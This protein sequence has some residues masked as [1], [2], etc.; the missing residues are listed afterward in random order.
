[1]VAILKNV[2][3]LTFSICLAIMLTSSMMLN[4]TRVEAQDMP[5]LAITDMYW[6]PEQPTK[7]VKISVVVRNI[8]KADVTQGFTVRL[9]IDSKSRAYWNIGGSDLP[10][11]PND[12]INCY[13]DES[14]APGPR[15]LKAVVDE[16]QRIRDADRS[17]NRMEKTLVISTST[18]TTSTATITRTSVRVSTTTRHIGTTEPSAEIERIDYPE[19]VQ[20]SEIFGIAV[21][22]TFALP[23]PARLGVFIYDLSK[24]TLLASQLSDNT[25]YGGI[26]Y[27]S[28]FLTSPD[29][30]MIWKLT[31]KAS[32]AKST[33]S[34]YGFDQKE[35]TVAVGSAT[36]E[37][38]TATYI[39]T[40][41]QRITASSSQ[42][43]TEVVETSSEISQPFVSS[44]AFIV[45][46]GVVIAAIFGAVLMERRRKPKVERYNCCPECGSRNELC[47]NYCW[48][49]GRPIGEGFT[50]DMG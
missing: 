11:Q 41:E 37:T 38:T 16:S 25:R 33:G 8:G 23:E 20:C 6:E 32:I 4:T 42:L 10:F 17:N 43:S 35:I 36:M 30:D 50:E 45:V 44:P 46:I 28:L 7:N 21:D 1:M 40:T 29:Y 15:R 49:C 9:Y 19:H 5:D 26:A 3:K 22:V 27:F 39:W 47:N 13:A 14:L 2:L 18:V 12:S 24:D 34:F 31:I 48:N